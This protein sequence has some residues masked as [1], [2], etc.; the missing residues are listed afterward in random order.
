MKFLQNMTIKKIWLWLAISLAVLAVFLVIANYYHSEVRH[1]Q[2]LVNNHLQQQIRIIDQDIKQIA[3]LREKRR[4]LIDYMMIT[5]EL[6][7]YNHF[8]MNALSSLVSNLPKTWKLLE[9][10]KRAE[11]L[12]YTLQVSSP[13]ALSIELGLIQLRGLEN[14]KNVSIISLNEDSKRNSRTIAIEVQFD[15]S[16]REEE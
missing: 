15:S 3:S 8:E 13:S 7:R 14:I 5:D 10:A 6:T 2:T 16:L 1:Q 9:F 11:N 12:S 4:M